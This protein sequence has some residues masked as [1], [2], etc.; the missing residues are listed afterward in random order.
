MARAHKCYHPG[1]YPI[2]SRDYQ[3]NYNQYATV[4]ILSTCISPLSYMKDNVE[5]LHVFLSFTRHMVY[6]L[7]NKNIQKLVFLKTIFGI[8]CMS[9]L[10][11]LLFG[12]RLPDILFWGSWNFSCHF[13]ILQLMW[14]SMPLFECFD[15]LSDIF[16]WPFWTG[17][18]YTK[19]STSIR[20]YSNMF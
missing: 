1:V 20:V 11:V 14:D 19:R 12:A 15:N 2:L 8:R 6:C 3:F 5:K 16:K 18:D 17:S 13:T 10:S 7:M 9:D 4:L